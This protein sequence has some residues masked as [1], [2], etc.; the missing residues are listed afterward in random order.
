M[1]QALS[2][3]WREP[4]LHFLLIGAALFLYYDIVGEDDSEAP[5]KRIL[6][7]SGQVAQLAASFERTHLFVPW[8]TGHLS[9]KRTLGEG[10]QHYRK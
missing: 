7:N 5:P 9:R 1:T 8:L 4:L 10:V 6:V 3:L 2:R